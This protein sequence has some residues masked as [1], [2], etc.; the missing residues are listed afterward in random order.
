MSK[1]FGL[2]AQIIISLDFHYFQLLSYSVYFLCL[3]IKTMG[4]QIFCINNI[5]HDTLLQPDILYLSNIYNPWTAQ[6]I[7]KEKSVLLIFLDNKVNISLLY[8]SK[9]QIKQNAAMFTYQFPSMK[10]TSIQIF[11]EK[12]AKYKILLTDFVS[13]WVIKRNHYLVYK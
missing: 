3:Q 1:R 7:I 2:H 12:K 9:Q 6:N 4:R 8:K 10:L 13:C 11:T 5:T